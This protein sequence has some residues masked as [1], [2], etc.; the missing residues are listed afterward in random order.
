LRSPSAA[1]RSGGLTAFA[2]FG[3]LGVIVCRAIYRSDLSENWTRL[4][5][6]AN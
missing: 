3:D 4:S 6:P 5:D 2:T 1:E